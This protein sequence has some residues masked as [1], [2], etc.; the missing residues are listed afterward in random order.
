MKQVVTYLTMTGFL[1]LGLSFCALAQIKT[2]SNKEILFTIQVNE[3]NRAVLT[4]VTS[5]GHR[6]ARFIVQR[7]K[8]NE[9]FFDIREIEVKESIADERLQ[10]TFIDSKAMRNTENYRIVEYESDGKFYVY[11]PLQAKPNSPVS[12]LKQS[13]RDIISV[14][15]DNN[16]NITALV[17]TESG[18]GVPCELELT[19]D[20]NVVLKPL[21]TLTSGSY[22]VK[23][24]SP[25][26][27]KMYKFSVKSDDI[28]S[29]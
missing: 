16:T 22:V 6:P 15:V 14:A 2:R 12:V 4:W 29:Q 11:A 13:D 19:N 1:F 24:R 9:T 21:Y 28:L 23:L 8:D 7:S 18:L 3:G 27:E 25:S 10:F 20:N 17:G 5:E 26:G